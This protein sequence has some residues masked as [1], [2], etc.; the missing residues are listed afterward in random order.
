MAGKFMPLCGVQEDTYC[1]IVGNLSVR[2]KG[3]V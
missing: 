2:I 1:A 3:V